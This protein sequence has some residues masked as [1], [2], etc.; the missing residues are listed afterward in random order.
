[1]T[2]SKILQTAKLFLK[3]KLLSFFSHNFEIT[4]SKRSK[5]AGFVLGFLTMLAVVL[6]VNAFIS[7]EFA[8]KWLLLAFCMVCPFVIG[9]SAAYTLSFKNETV[10]KNMALHFFVF[11]A[12]YNYNY[13]RMS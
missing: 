9:L 11:N 4:S 13:N 5:I 3:E 10:K 6:N 12:I 8:A 2:F 1:M 7:Q